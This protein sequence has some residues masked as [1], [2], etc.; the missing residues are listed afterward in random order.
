M[1]I[2]VELV[3]SDKINLKNTFKFYVN[4]IQLEPMN[5]DPLL[6]KLPSVVAENIPEN[7]LVN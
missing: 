6:K 5:A 4:N 7:S 1:N 3:H 2:Y